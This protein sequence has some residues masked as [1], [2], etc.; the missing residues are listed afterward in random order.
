MAWEEMTQ[1]T[2]GQH[3]GFDPDIRHRTNDSTLSLALVAR[4]QAVTLL[5][6]LVLPGRHPGIAL[7]G[8]AEASV[9]R[10]VFAVTRVTDRAR[11]STQ[12]LLAAVR[13][14][15]AALPDSWFLGVPLDRREGALRE[16]RRGRAE[17]APAALS[18][19]RE[20]LSVETK[21]VGMDRTAPVSPPAWTRTSQIAF[22]YPG[23][24]SAP[25]SCGSTRSA[26]TPSS[27]PA[28]P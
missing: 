14:V 7:R 1:R 11:P 6:G 17:G 12:A 27:R 15:A 8:I 16:R 3:G 21:R 9:E 4:G 24:S 13:D 18:R 22:T 19:S 23:R 2:C 28:I 5:P 25:R 26:G 10:G 20:A